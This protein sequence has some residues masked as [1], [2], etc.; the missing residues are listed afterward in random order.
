MHEPY[1]DLFPFMVI[2]WRSSLYS[3]N[4]SLETTLKDPSLSLIDAAINNDG[5]IVIETKE[6]WLQIWNFIF[7]NILAELWS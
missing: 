1:I 7:H 3:A 4:D 5:S 6:K 2:V